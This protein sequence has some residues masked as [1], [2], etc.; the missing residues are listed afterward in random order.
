VKVD[1]QL[2]EEQIKFLYS[3]AWREQGIP[4]EIVGIINLLEAIEEDENE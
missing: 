1:K 2:L 4:D 3:Y